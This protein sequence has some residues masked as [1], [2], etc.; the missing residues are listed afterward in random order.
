MFKQASLCL[1]LD[2]QTKSIAWFKALYACSVSCLLFTGS[3]LLYL[4]VRAALL[5]SIFSILLV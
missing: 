4:Y 1:H 2:Q 5:G 3:C